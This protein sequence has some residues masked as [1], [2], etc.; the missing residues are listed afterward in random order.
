MKTDT[1]TT[2]NIKEI[3][4]PTLILWGEQDR[5]IPIHNTYRFHND[6][7]NNTLVILKNSGHVPMEE[8]PKESLNAVLQF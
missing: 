3:Q 8:N 7:P 4:Q 5:L 6:L 1:P 2:S